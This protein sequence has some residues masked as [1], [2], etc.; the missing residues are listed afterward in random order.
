VTSSLEVCFPSAFAGRVAS[1]E[2]ASLRTIPLRRLVRRRSRGSPEVGAVASPNF[3]RPCGFVALCSPRAR[4][5]PCVSV[6]FTV[7]TGPVRVIAPRSL[8]RAAFRYPLDQALPRLGRIDLIDPAT[9]MGFLV[10]FAVFPGGAGHAHFCASSPHAVSRFARLPMVPADFYGRRS[11]IW[12]LL[13]TG[14]GRCSKNAT[15][16]CNVRATP[17]GFW[18]VLPRPS[19]ACADARHHPAALAMDAPVRVSRAR[20]RTPIL[21]WA[22][23][24]LLSG[25]SD[26]VS[27]ARAFAPRSSSNR[28]TPPIAAAVPFAGL[29]SAR[30]FSGEL[31]Q[32]VRSGSRL[33]SI[34][35]QRRHPCRRRPFSV[36]GRFAPSRSKRSRSS[37]NR[38]WGRASVSER[39][40]V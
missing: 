40:P 5:T 28:G 12:E 17:T 27:A 4:P 38:S 32:D 37:H 18:V 26:A 36:F 14:G 35:Q 7:Y 23:C 11:R 16:L 39:L 15:G 21:P 29:P 30:G 2:A 25:V 1:S 3:L 10:P 34:E 19:R 31:L 33:L 8:F 24:W 20:L 6:Y 22:F 13:P 9:L